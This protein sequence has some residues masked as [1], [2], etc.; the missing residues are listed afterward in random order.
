MRRMFQ[1]KKAAHCRIMESALL[2]M[3]Q[4]NI[5]LGIL[6]VALRESRYRDKLFDGIENAFRN[7]NMRE[8]G[9]DDDVRDDDVAVELRERMVRD[10]QVSTDYHSLAMWY[11]ELSED[12]R[13]RIVGTSADL[14]EIT[15]PGKP[16][17]VYRWYRWHGDKIACFLLTVL[18]PIGMLWTLIFGSGSKQEVATGYYWALGIGQM[19]IAGHVMVGRVMVWTLGYKFRKTLRRFVTAVEKGRAQEGPNHSPFEDVDGV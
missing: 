19:S 14:I 8:E 10:S 17:R 5:A 1:C 11:G 18:I 13:N 12:R 2:A 6:Y 15:D 7:E 3:L 4:I 9:N 16:P